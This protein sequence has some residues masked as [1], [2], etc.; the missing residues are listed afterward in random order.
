MRKSL[1]QMAYY[2]T[3][4]PILISRKSKSGSPTSLDKNSF[5]LNTAYSH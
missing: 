2:T 5:V 1:L 4:R 3:S